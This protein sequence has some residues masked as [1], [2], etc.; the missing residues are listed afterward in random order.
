MILET[1]RLALREVT[2]DDLDFLAEIMADPEVMRFYPQV[3]ARAEARAW[4]DRQLAHYAGHG[5]GN[6]LVL[7]RIAGRPVGRCGLT[8]QDVDGTPEPEI[9]YVIHK[10]FW[11]R[12]YATE[13]ALA[14][15]DWAFAVKGLAR[16]IS[17][18]RPENV[19]SQGVARKLGMVPE[20]ETD[21][22]GMRHLVFAVRRA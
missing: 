21:H 20:G 17:L 19:P 16:V 13:A 15:R 11:R 9:G 14:V 6:W 8:Y 1:D 3:Y 22:A 12:G 5:H 4:I 10:P 7:D 18:V 2:P